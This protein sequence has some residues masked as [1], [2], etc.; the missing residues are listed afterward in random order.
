[1]DADRVVTISEQESRDLQ[2][3]FGLDPR[4]INVIANGIDER[5]FHASKGAFVDRYGLDNIV[6]CVGSIEPR[7]NQ[8]VVANALKE[9]GRPVVFIG[10]PCFTRW[11]GDQGLCAIIRIARRPV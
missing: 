4:K 1:M 11:T 2:E 10:P 6:L 8:V 5:F 9:I 3:G 7:K